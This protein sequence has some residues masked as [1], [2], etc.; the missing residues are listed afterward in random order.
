MAAW[1]LGWKRD[2]L[3]SCFYISP[4]P[5]FRFF[6]PPFIRGRELAQYRA[7]EGSRHETGAHHKVYENKCD[8]QLEREGLFP[9][10]GE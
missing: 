5:T 3:S 9:T 4:S 7:Q 1:E 8:L 10:G 6:N 2:L